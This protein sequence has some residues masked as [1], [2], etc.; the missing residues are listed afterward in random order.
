MSALAPKADVSR[1][2]YEYTLLIV[3][4]VATERVVS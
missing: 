2:V 4:G 3:L 1:R